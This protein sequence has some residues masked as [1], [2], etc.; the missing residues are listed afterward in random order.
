MI[1]GRDGRD[2]PRVSCE[3]NVRPT[4]ALHPPSCRGGCTPRTRASS[5][6]TSASPAKGP[7]TFLLARCSRGRN[8]LSPNPSD[9][10]LGLAVWGTSY[11]SLSLSC[12]PRQSTLRRIWKVFAHCNASCR[13]GTHK[14][15]EKLIPR[16]DKKGGKPRQKKGNR[17]K[18][19]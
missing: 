11:L 14:G 4:R 15:G 12:F 17:G 9:E 18:G 13:E 3:G 6:L 19:N 1:R 8:P 10:S 16:R 2:T 5:A 7:L